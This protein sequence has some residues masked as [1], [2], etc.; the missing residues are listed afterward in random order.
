MTNLKT[1]FQ[2]KLNVKKKTFFCKLGSV[3]L[4]DNAKFTTKLFL[5]AFFEEWF[6]VQSVIKLVFWK[7]NVKGFLN[8]YLIIPLHESKRF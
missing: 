5:N 7:E 8:L 4:T 6:F 3:L 1:N 2:R